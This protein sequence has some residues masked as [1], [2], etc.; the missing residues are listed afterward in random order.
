M[1]EREVVKQAAELLKGIIRSID[2]K[3]EYSLMEQ[4]QEGRFSLRLSSRGRQGIVSL[5]TDDLRAAVSDN[6]RKNAI[7]QKIKSTRDHLLSN[8]VVDVMGK[9]VA[10]MLKQAGAKDESAPSFFRRP[11][12]RRR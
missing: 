12:G 8:Y 1:T 2:K 7:R 11:Q 10:K 5:V 9:K 6:V 4:T 3:L